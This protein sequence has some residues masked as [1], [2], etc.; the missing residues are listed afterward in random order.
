MA[1]RSQTLMVQKIQQRPTVTRTHQTV[2]M[3]DK[4]AI[5]MEMKTKTNNRVETRPRTIVAR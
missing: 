4:H 1:R 5:A 2:L 3:K